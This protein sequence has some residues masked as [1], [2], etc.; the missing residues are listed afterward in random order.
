MHQIA[1]RVLGVGVHIHPDAAAHPGALQRAEHSGQRVRGRPRRRWWPAR[2][3]GV[4]RPCA[5]RFPRRGS[6]RTGRRCAAGQC[7]LP[8]AGSLASVIRSR[9][10]SSARS[11]RC[12]E[13]AVG[14]PVRGHLVFGQPAAVDVAEQ[15]VL[16]SG[17]RVDIAQV[18][19]R[20]NGLYS[21]PAILPSCFG[22]NDRAM[23]TASGP[24]QAAEQEE[25]ADSADESEPD[26]PS[27]NRQT[28]QVF[29]GYGVASTV[30]GVLSVAAVVLGV[31]IW[32]AHRDDAG[33]RI[34]LSRVMQTAADWTGVLINM[35]SGN[36]DASLQRL[37][38]GHG[39]RTQ[40][41]LRRRHAALPA[42]GAEAAVAAAPAGSSRWRSK[43][44][45][46]TWTP[47]PVTAA[48]RRHHQAAARSPAEPTR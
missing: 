5:R 10:C 43:P 46:T 12:A 41:R 33:E 48:A 28:V 39:R 37:H 30:L 31:L 15:V 47:S 8:G 35:N 7:R 18:D 23:P 44:C 9:T 21:H 2:R 45:T 25:P 1:G 42:G 27:P 3:A 36:L 40:H 11:N 22:C 34:Y 19:A 16:G 24:S 26:L 14:R 6:W 20:A 29:S 17:V 38:D 13:R 32:P 4:A